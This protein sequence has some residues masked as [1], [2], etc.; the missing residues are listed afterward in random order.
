MDQ[1]NVNPSKTGARFGV[2]TYA[3]KPEVYFNFKHLSGNKINPTMV[4][5]LIDTVPRVKG[6][7][8]RIDSALELVDSKLFNP[9]AGA[10]V[11]AKPVSMTSM[12]VIPETIDIP[13]QYDLML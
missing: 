12:E 7:N 8:R 11:G 2:V 3:N 1:F 4:K 6:T 10:R 9:R 5:K 13:Y